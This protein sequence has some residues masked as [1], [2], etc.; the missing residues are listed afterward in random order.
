MSSTVHRRIVQRRAK[1]GCEEAYE[2]MVRA[3]FKESMSFPGF[4]SAELI[5]PDFPG[6]EYQIIQHFATADDLERWNDSAVRM[7]WLERLRA[8]A[9]GDPEYRVLNGLD[10]WFAPVTLPATI[11]PPK[12]KMTV[13][14]WLGIFPTV[15][16][17]LSFLSPLIAPLPFSLRTAIFTAVVAV[18]MSYVV[19]PRVS[20][21]MAWW[22]KR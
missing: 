19:M 10:A 8:V 18:L 1:A 7:V 3:M 17:L 21:W 15:A 16:L 12:W 9:D 4:I 5:P 22:L 13:V 14:S 2:S 20:R 6:G 11:H